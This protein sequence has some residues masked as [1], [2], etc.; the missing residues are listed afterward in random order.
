MSDASTSTIMNAEG[1]GLPR[2]GK[3][4][5]FCLICLTMSVC[6]T[7]QGLGFFLTLLYRGLVK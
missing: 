3:D 5:T 1:W 7:D 6:T 4:S 2:L